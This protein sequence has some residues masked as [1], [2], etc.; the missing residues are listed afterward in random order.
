MNVLVGCEYSNTVAGAFR[1][2]GH[3]AWSCDLLPSEG[4]PEWHIQGDVFDAL[5]SVR[6]YK[7]AWTIEE[8]SQEVIKQ[9]G[10]QFNPEV[11]DKFI[12]FLPKFKKIKEEYSSQKLENVIGR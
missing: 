5:T 11:V 10:R 9:K 8:A 6:P 12:E 1:D 7:K 4:P 2:A 3:T